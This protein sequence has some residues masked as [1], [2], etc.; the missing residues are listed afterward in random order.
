[1][2]IHQKASILVVDDSKF[3]RAVILKTLQQINMKIITA[4]NGQEALIKV[5]ENTFDLIIT[6]TVMPVMDGIT[7]I[8]EIKQLKTDDFVPI[9]LMTGTD[10]QNIKVTSLNVGADDFIKKPIDQRELVARVFSLLRLKKMHDLL[11]EKNKIIEKELEVAKRVQNQIIPHDFSHIQYPQVYGFYLPMEDIGGDFYDCYELP[12]GAI[13]FLIADVT[14]HGIPAALIVTMTKMLFSVYAGRYT[15]TKKL[16]TRVNREI[17]GS[18]TSDQYITSF[19]CIYNPESGL[20]SFSNAGHML[21]LLYKKSSQ[22]V[23]SLNTEKGFFLGIQESCI[24]DQK[25]VRIDEGDCLLMY[26][27]GLSEIKNKTKEEYGEKGLR[28]FLLENHTMPGES[29]CRALYEDVMAHSN[30]KLRYDDIS[31]LF[32]KF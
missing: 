17:F 22:R 28:S 24:Y 6:D 7:L 5:K 32:I 12:N 14:G 13:G 23:Y 3:N 16:F 29:F 18:L 15:S 31:F 2:F 4:C 19:Y 1:M 21:P 26:T 25:A 10:D 8:K 20:L 11:Y 30:R 9:I 27:D